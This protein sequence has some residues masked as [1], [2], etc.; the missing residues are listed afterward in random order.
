MNAVITKPRIAPG[1]T[2]ECSTV[3]H[4]VEHGSQRAVIILALAVVLIIG[5]LMLPAPALSTQAPA[6]QPSVCT[7]AC[8]PATQTCSRLPANQVPS[9]ATRPSTVPLMY[10]MVPG[11]TRC[12]S[13]ACVQDPYACVIGTI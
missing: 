8:N 2:D 9:M 3:A 12:D 10:K 11:G 13:S 6:S 7:L 5:V 4:E 1:F